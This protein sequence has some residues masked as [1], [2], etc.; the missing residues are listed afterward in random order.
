[1]KTSTTS[2]A[3]VTLAKA[4]NEQ[5]PLTEKE[6]ER[7]DK[8]IAI[9]NP[10]IDNYPW[11]QLRDVA[12]KCFN[13]KKDQ[14]NA[15][16]SDSAIFDAPNAWGIYKTTGGKCLGVVGNGYEVIEPLEFLRIIHIAFVQARKESMLKEITFNELFDGE[17]FGFKVPLK[18][19]EIKTKLEV[20][21]VTEM[22]LDFKTGLNG[23][24]P[25]TLSINTKR[26]W[27]ANGC[28]STEVGANHSFKHLTNKN[29]EVLK[30]A[31]S[32][33]QSINVADNHIRVMEIFAKK[34]L[35]S[36][37][38]NELFEKITGYN[39]K[40]FTSKDKKITENLHHTQVTAFEKMWG[41]MQKEIEETGSTAYGF[42]NGITQY[43]NHWATKL[44]E[45]KQPNFDKA[46][47]NEIKAYYTE[48]ERVNAYNALISERTPEGE[49]ARIEVYEFNKK[50]KELTA[51]TI[52]TLKRYCDIEEVAEVEA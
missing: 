9:K 46:S 47:D 25:S 17:V 41:A 2:K 37:E 3:S 7:V 33:I 30:Y 28:S 21:D 35:V 22:F 15:P 42:L 27:C 6:Q 49:Q 1:M 31:L 50:L 43:T 48:L 36:E 45:P 18:K 16:N 20:G 14:L 34:E 11:G 24:V 13:V 8:L 44:A 4:N 38:V 32:L 52:N 5:L 40:T 39:V 12:S 23:R 29:K 19:F 26:L 10:T 51:T